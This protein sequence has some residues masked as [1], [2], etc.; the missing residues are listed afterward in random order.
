MAAK[1]FLFFLGELIVGMVLVLLYIPFSTS[2]TFLLLRFLRLT[3]S[4][5]FYTF[6]YLKLLSYKSKVINLILCVYFLIS[7][8][9]L[10]NMGSIS[11]LQ[12]TGYKLGRYIFNLL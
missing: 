8:F 2:S 11:L 1:L 5:T 7:I 6:M 9:F 4:I 3:L 12:W 10:A